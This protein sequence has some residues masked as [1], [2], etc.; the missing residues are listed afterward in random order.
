MDP[1]AA[2]LQAANG[3]SGLPPSI[4][5][6]PGAQPAQGGAQGAQ[7]PPA[8]GSSRTTNDTQVA[9]QAASHLL[10]FSAHAS[11]PA[12][13]AIFSGA[14]NGLHKYLAQDEKEHQAALQGKL[15]PRIMAKAHGVSG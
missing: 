3:H 7:M 5:M 8:A 12:L 2:I 4:A 14:L 1:L 11:D 10:A 6:S 13:K 15:S 9:Q